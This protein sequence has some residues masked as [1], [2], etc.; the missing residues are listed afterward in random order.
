MSTPSQA[1]SGRYQ[2]EG[3]V[4]W[5]GEPELSFQFARTLGGAQEGASLISECFAAASRMTPGDT[6]SWYREWQVFAQKS[7][8]RAEEA[9]ARGR[10]RTASSNWLRASN[11][12]RSS[13]F[14]LAHD[15]PRRVDTFDSVE[16]CSHRYLAGLHPAGEVVAIPYENG[17]HLDAYFLPCAD[18]SVRSPVV[19]AFGGLDEYKDELL[20]EM[21]KHALTRGMS[22]LLVDM[23]GQGGTLRRQKI[24][25]RPDTHVPVGAC[26][27][28]LLT[29]SDVDPAKIALYGASVGGVYAARAASFEKRLVATVSDSVMFDMSSLFEGWLATPE[30][31]IWRHLKWVFG[32][33]TAEEVVEKAKAFRLEGVINRIDMPYL[34]LQGTED[35]LGLKTATDTYDYARANGVDAEL[36]LFDP[37]E[38][39]AAHCQIDNPTLGQEFICD[40]LAGHLGIDQGAVRARMSALA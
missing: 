34:V 22:L 24:V 35:W 2:K 14:Y 29:R 31:L 27:D 7:E 5:L 33:A 6:E 13:E 1:S 11:Y 17:A 12:Y 18:S 32:C 30:R 21:P 38:T 37:A 28:Y 40:W 23:P 25:N 39:G 15:D 9:F 10:F 36:R 20:H 4:Q 19:I 3:W 26:I 8:W 16:R